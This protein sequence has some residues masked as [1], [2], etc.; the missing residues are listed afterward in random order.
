MNQGWVYEQGNFVVASHML[1][2]PGSAPKTSSSEGLSLFPHQVF[3]PSRQ[4]MTALGIFE[5][6]PPSLIQCKSAI[7]FNY[8]RGYNAARY[9]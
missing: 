8:R 6:Q 5:R 2:V 1:L 3:L 4:E 7:G 9:S